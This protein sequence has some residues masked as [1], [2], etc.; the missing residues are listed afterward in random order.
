MDTQISHGEGI[1][2]T[3]VP[4]FFRDETMLTYDGLSID[5]KDVF[6]AFLQSGEI[7]IQL[8]V[9]RHLETRC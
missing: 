5:E 2:V 7:N 4:K 8:I 1:I 6:E 3:V 9:H